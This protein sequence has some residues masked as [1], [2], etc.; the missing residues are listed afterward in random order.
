MKRALIFLF[1]SILFINLYADVLSQKERDF[2][3]VFFDGVSHETVIIRCYDGTLFGYTEEQ[4]G[5]VFLRISWLKEKLRKQKKTM[6]DIKIII[7][8]HLPHRPLCTQFSP[9]DRK[10]LQLLR[11]QGFDG[12]YALWADGKI[13]QIIK[14]VTNVTHRKEGPPGSRRARKKKKESIN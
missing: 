9:A 6:A 8:N 3:V 5:S 7:H 4:E 10:Q 1:S 11:N 2:F 12:M 14:E 13:A